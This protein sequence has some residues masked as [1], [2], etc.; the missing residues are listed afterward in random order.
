MRVTLRLS[1]PGD[2]DALRAFLEKRECHVEELASDLLRVGLPHELHDQQAR[3][4]V[5]LYASGSPCT[6][7]ALRSFRSRTVLL[8]STS[9]LRRRSAARAEALRDGR[10]L[11]RRPSVRAIGVW[12]GRP[13]AR[14]GG[15][16]GSS[17]CKP[18]PTAEGLEDPASG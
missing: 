4:E 7:A 8:Q 5:D 11:E 13:F 14:K 9:F 16:A 10:R 15:A 1:N 2:R 3:L 6:T 12:E 18:T 17:A